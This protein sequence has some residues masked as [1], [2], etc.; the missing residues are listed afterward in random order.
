[1][2][3]VARYND[4]ADALV[5]L[6]QMPRAVL[7]VH[8]GMLIY[9]SCQLTLGTRRGSLAALAITLLLA[10]F[11]ELMNR[12]FHGSWR[13]ADTTGDLGLSLFWPAMHYGISRFRRWRWQRR[14]QARV[15]VPAARPV[16]RTPVAYG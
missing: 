7:H 14:E 4:A 6:T 1:M 9:L 2:D 8:V 13:W 16:R 10:L 12:I 3:I 5:V 15:A 11:H